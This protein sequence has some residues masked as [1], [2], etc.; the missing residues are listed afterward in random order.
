MK[1]TSTRVGNPTRPQRA[2]KQVYL[3]KTTRKGAYR[4][5]AKQNFAIRR[6]PF[7]E[8]KTVSNSDLADKWIG[9]QQILNTL[10]FTNFNIGSNFQTLNPHCY[11][12]MRQGLDDGHMVGR[13][14][15]SRTLLVN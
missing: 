2:K 12:V 8:G 6:R 7:V 4:R 14:V 5:K 9:D 11:W 10:S 13:Q 15:F 3:K 1:R